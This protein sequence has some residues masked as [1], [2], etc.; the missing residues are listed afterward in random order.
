MSLPNWAC[1]AH[2]EKSGAFCSGKNKIVQKKRRLLCRSSLWLHQNVGVEKEM[3]RVRHVAVSGKGVG[4]LYDAEKWGR[5]DLRE[6]KTR[7]KIRRNK[8]ERRTGQEN[9]QRGWEDKLKQSD[10][11]KTVGI[12]KLRCES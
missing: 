1:A 8:W 10:L 11:Q 2:W 9:L 12:S 4:F 6:G 7:Q 3:E 5:K